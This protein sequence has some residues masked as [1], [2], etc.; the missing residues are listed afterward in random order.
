M[1]PMQADG[2]TGALRASYEVLSAYTNIVLFSIQDPGNLVQ[3][4]ACQA[5]Y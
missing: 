4:K 1:P 2:G 5:I 3:V